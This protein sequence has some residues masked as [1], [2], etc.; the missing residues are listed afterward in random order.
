MGN[1][2]ADGVAFPIITFF[3]MR[4]GFQ[5]ADVA[6]FHPETFFRVGVAL[7]FFQFAKEY[8]LTKKENTRAQY[9]QAL[10]AFARYL[11]K[12]QIDVN[13]ITR[14]M[15]GE[16][17][18]FMDGEKK[19]HYNYATGERTETS[20][21][22]AKGG[23]AGRHIVKLAAIYKAAKNKYNDE[24]ID[25]VLIPRSPFD[26]HKVALPAAQG[27]KALPM[28]TIQRMIQAQPENAQ[29]R[30]KDPINAHIHPCDLVHTGTGRD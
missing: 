24:D 14:T 25:Q 1:D 12:E 15:V 30:A 23:Q 10:N 19:L 20:K 2:L 5:T 27:Q 17:I 29:V 22:K 21:G 16:F 11:K 4:M 6:L 7:D 9:V 13:Q 28:E 18:A 3:R 26:G 8:L